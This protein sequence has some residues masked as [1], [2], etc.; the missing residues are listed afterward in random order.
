MAIAAVC[1]PAN[2]A[3]ENR[4]AALMQVFDMTLISGGTT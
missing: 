4:S 2:E 3:N 1:A